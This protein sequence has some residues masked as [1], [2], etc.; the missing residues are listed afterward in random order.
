VRDH[1]FPLRRSAWAVAVAALLCTSVAAQTLYKSVGPD[2]KPVYS[3]KPPAEGTLQ[4]TLKADKLPNTA[5]PA[6]VAEELERLKRSGVKAQ[7][8][9]ADVV[10]YAAAWCGWCLQA[11]AYLTRARIAHRDIDIDTPEGKR[12]FAAAG[13]GGVPLIVIKGQPPLRGYSELAYD[14]LFAN[15]R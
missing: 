7:P 3:D 12:A 4:K 5:L 14:G 2:G 1:T 11:R 9:A 8:P 6:D 15:H 10:L 13:G